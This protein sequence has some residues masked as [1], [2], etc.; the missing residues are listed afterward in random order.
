MIAAFGRAF[1]RVRFALWYGRVAVI[2]GLA[3]CLG[4]SG[5]VTYPTS[6]GPTPNG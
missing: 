2:H 1:A 6:K 4:V 3:W 5:N